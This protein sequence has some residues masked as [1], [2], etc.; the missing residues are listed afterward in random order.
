MTKSE[1]DYSL[2]TDDELLDVMAHIDRYSYPDR[3]NRVK[4]EIE[5]RKNGVSSKVNKRHSKLPIRKGKKSARW[6][7]LVVWS[8]SILL[9]IYYGEM[10]GRAGTVIYEED[11]G[12]FVIYLIAF[13]CVGI[14]FYNKRDDT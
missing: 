1:P 8:M 7:V 3:Y 2:Y 9:A 5:N 11:P 14:Y 12:F 6:G 4:K 10:P 13:I